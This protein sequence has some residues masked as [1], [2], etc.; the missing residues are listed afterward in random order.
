MRV[1]RSFLNS[2]DG[3]D[4]KS[5]P[6]SLSLSLLPKRRRGFEKTRDARLSS[7]FFFFFFFFAAAIANR[8]R[9]IFDFTSIASL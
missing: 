7:L 9:I 4:D 1:G 3:Y 8:E 2:R 5:L 6:L